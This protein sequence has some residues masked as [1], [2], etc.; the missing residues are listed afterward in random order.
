MITELSTAAGLSVTAIQSQTTGVWQV[1]TAMNGLVI[2]ASSAAGAIGQVTTTFGDAMSNFT[3]SMDAAIA[4]GDKI[5]GL[6][7]GQAG[8]GTVPAFSPSGTSNG[9]TPST[10]VIIANAGTFIAGGAGA[11]GGG[12]TNP[13]PGSQWNTGYP[14]GPL[15]QPQSGGGSNVTV[16]ITGNSIT[17]QALVDQLAN[18][19]GDVIITS[20]RTRAGLKL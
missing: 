19:V 6:S 15:S 2:A 11:V 10:D 3:T 8:Y 1:V 17:S 4:A 7:P 5:N 20:L 12:W 18:K 14:D 9:P 16:N 13:N